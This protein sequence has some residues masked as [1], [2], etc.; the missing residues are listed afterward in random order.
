[1]LITRSLLISFSLILSLS[2]T[3]SI[4][5]TKTSKYREI[6]WVELI[7]DDDLN[8]LMNPPDTVNDIPDGSALDQ[9]NGS[10]KSNISNMA[11]TAYSRALVST[12]IKPEF[13]NQ[14]I[15]V[16]GFI[17]PIDLNSRQKITSF[18][19][20]PYFGACIHV[21]PPPP[22]Q[23]I[24]SEYAKG[25]T[26]DNLYTAYWLEGT[27]KTQIIENEVATSAYTLIVDNIEIY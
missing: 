17:V 11:N 3:Y 15:R 10:L 20:V 24:F 14:K 21:P 1:M 9:L 8:A 5:D 2:S 16:P 22:N 7:P 19:L 26:L 25:L 4:A 23:I 12:Q 27:M 18:F 13:N 6:E